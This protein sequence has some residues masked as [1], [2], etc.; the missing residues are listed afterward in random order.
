MYEQTN[1]LTEKICKFMYV[2]M[3]YAAAPFF[4]LPKAFYSF[5]MYFT[6]DLGNGAFEL[7]IPTWLVVLILI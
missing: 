1:R 3:V 2:F 5:I 4:I 6:T 7:P